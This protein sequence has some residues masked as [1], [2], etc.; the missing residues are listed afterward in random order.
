MSCIKKPSRTDKYVR[1]EGHQN[2]QEVTMMPAFY[3]AGGLQAREPTLNPTY[4][5]TNENDD[6]CTTYGTAYH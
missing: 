2:G 1:L 4:I 5:V 3:V 6:A